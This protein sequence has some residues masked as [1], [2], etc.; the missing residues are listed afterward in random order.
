MSE[1][2]LNRFKEV[3]TL[4][5][6]TKD[7]IRQNEIAKK[8]VELYKK[9]SSTAI[10]VAYDNVNDN[11]YI[12][13]GTQKK[14][15]FYPC[16][17]AH[18]DQVHYTK[19]WYKIFQ[20]RDTLF[21]MGKTPSGTYVQV[22]T[23][24]DDLTG[25]WCALELLIS[26]PIL[27]VALFSDEERGCIGSTKAEMDFFKDVSFVMQA[28]R[29]GNTKDFVTYSNGAEINSEEFQLAA[30]TY[31]EPLGYK[32]SNGISTDVGQL[33]KNKIGI[34]TVNLSCGYFFPHTDREVSSIKDS[35]I[36]LDLMEKMAANLPYKRWEFTPP[37]KKVSTYD[38]YS[39]N[40][41]SWPDDNFYQKGNY[42]PKFN[43]SK[44]TTTIQKDPFSEKFT[45]DLCSTS[46]KDLIGI[47]EFFK[48]LNYKYFPKKD[49]TSLDLD[50]TFSD[51]EYMIVF[52][53][54]KN[55]K[56]FTR[57]P[58][59][60]KSFD[61]IK[62]KL[63]PIEYTEFSK[64]FLTE[65]GTKTNNNLFITNVRQDLYTCPYC[66]E[67]YSLVKRN[68]YYIDCSN[69]LCS[70]KNVSVYILDVKRASSGMT[71][72]TFE[73]IKKAFKVN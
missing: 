39:T 48:K 70:F 10:K 49:L 71:P 33:T 8:F 54:S 17:V 60:V 58:Q 53:Q 69:D 15:M 22:G 73:E 67:Q 35:F 25:V 45:V 41:W 59:D 12:T 63:P 24:S 61:I 50:D 32:T 6:E 65:P 43:N 44:S 26:Q 1:I 66:R 14:G 68:N 38:K 16:V 7:L 37:E 13:K 47:R 29:K 40:A 21:A 56:V 42:N 19:A 31:F 2:Q 52:P 51:A 46:F 30:K 5:A 36:C 55:L 18:L 9:Y 34:S 11:Y 64:K 27:K 23:G 3:L 20:D 57:S 62:K 72:A 28:D 4:Q